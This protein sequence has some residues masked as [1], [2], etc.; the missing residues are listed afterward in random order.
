VDAFLSAP[1]LLGLAAAASAVPHSGGAAQIQ[2]NQCTLENVKLEVGMPRLE[3]ET[4]IAVALGKQ[5]AYSLYANNLLGGSVEY[6]DIAC[7]LKVSFRP[8]APAALLRTTEGD[9]VHRLPID[10][11]IGEFKLE[12]V[13][14]PD[15]EPAMPRADAVASC[16]VEAEPP[17]IGV[18]KASR[19]S[20]DDL[21]AFLAKAT[22]VS[23]ESW[24]HNYSHVAS[25]DCTGTITLRTGE[26]I[27]WLI[28]PGGLG[29]L[30]F[31]DGRELFLVRCCKDD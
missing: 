18:S 26:R 19:V 11:S 6:R 30:T 17:N 8:G 23:H 4:R 25:S 3:A 31:A 28:R 20:C 14:S 21:L 9:I 2:D 7:T 1:L 24:L 16:A 29:R 13:R 12:F 27:R 5:N 10:E 15:R 22:T